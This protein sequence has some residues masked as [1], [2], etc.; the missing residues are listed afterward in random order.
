M[1]RSLVLVED[2]EGNQLDA[3][4]VEEPHPQENHGEGDV[5][6]GLREVVA[7]EHGEEGVNAN[8]EAKWEDDKDDERN[9]TEGSRVITKP[10]IVHG[11]NSGGCGHGDGRYDENDVAADSF[12]K[13][14]GDD[15]TGDVR[16]EVEDGGKVGT[17]R[18]IVW[19]K[20]IRIVLK[21]V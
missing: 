18:I 15:A 9:V 6:P 7:N 3:N 21:C 2:D 20:V 4:I 11:Q 19:D 16:G 13:E 10:E 1:P 8:A 14:G 17:V 5:L 12:N